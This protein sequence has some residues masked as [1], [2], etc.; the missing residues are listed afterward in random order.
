MTNKTTYREIKAKGGLTEI[1]AIQIF[2][3]VLKLPSIGV[4]DTKCGFEITT[5]RINRCPFCKN[6]W[7]DVSTNSFI[8]NEDEVKK[9]I[10]SDIRYELLMIEKKF[11]DYIKYNRQRNLNG[12]KHE[13]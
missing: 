7:N 3:T 2:R 5:P 4:N 1:D 6:T 12:F 13:T 9:G 11:D 10:L 8:C